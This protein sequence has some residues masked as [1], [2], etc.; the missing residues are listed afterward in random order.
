MSDSELEQTV[1]QLQ[2]QLRAREAELQQAMNR[3]H[4]LE[5]C[6]D[7][8]VLFG[9]DLSPTFLN[10][11]GARLYQHIHAGSIDAAETYTADQVHSLEEVLLISVFESGQPATVGYKA[12]HPAQ[13]PSIEARYFPEEI[14]DGKV[15]S[16]LAILRDDT[17]R[18]RASESMQVNETL[19][20]AAVAHA[21]VKIYAQD[22]EL[23]YQW[24]YDQ[25]SG[26]MDQ[27][28]PGK[29]DQDFYSPADAEKLNQIKR[30]VLESGKSLREMVDL[31]LRN[32]VRS[33]ELYI[34]PMRN[35]GEITGL[36]CTSLDI[37]E[38]KRTAQQLAQLA[39]ENQAQKDRLAQQNAFLQGIF[40]ASPAGIAVLVGEELEHG[41][42]NP[43]YRSMLPHP[44][45]D[46]LGRP[47]IEVWPQAENFRGSWIAQRVLQ[48]GNP[49]HLD[50]YPQQFADGATRY[51]GIN[52][53]RL[54]WE[55]R[56][57]VL[58]VL[59]DVTSLEAATQL[60]EA[61]ADEARKRAAEAQESWS[62]L[63]ASEQKLRL[64]LAAAHMGSWVYDPQTGMVEYDEPAQKLYDVPAGW[65]LHS[66]VY[67]NRYH[68]EDI[69]TMQKAEQKATD[70]HGDGRYLVDYRVR[71]PDGTWRWLRVWGQVQFT[72]EGANRRA[73]WMIGASRDITER[74]QMEVMLR[75]NEE[76]FRS[77]FANAAIGFAM[78]DP[79]GK[80]ADANAAYCQLTGYTIEEL[81]KLKSSDLFYPDDYTENMRLTDEMLAG[82]ISDYVVENRYVRKNKQAVWV[83][84][85]VSMVRDDHSAPKWIILL[86]ENISQR[87]QAEEAVHRY[88]AQLEQLNRELA[89]TNRELKDFAYI[90]SHDLQEPLRKVSKF[91]EMLK[92]NY[93]AVLAEGGSEYVDRMINASQR[94]Q[95]MISGLL[96]YS[97]ISTRGSSFTEVNL[98]ETAR[99]VLSDLEIRLEQTGGAVELG[100]LPV[101]EADPL[102][103]RQLFQN[104]IGNALKFHQDGIPPQVKV[105][106]EECAQRD[107]KSGC[108]Q[109]VVQD[110]G[111]GFESHLADKLF[112]P[113]VRLH[114]RSAYEGTGMGLAICRKI[115]ERH[116]G[117]IAVSSQPEQG[118]AF[119]ITLPMRQSK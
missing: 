108:I 93:G 104:L 65:L 36:L 43:A 105:W 87:K 17:G 45:D 73:G 70:P 52:I 26:L 82:Q 74:K 28:Y 30:Q 88:T 111:I 7:G 102:Q 76:K 107:Q 58:M 54:D 57:A 48:S 118:T 18:K 61:A 56:P 1:R 84:K 119:T 62:K 75:E 90:A 72:G 110:N 47:Y 97:R 94:M 64:A 13:R 14:V 89:F 91:G 21:G 113:F 20:R 53:S 19:V 50:R 103:I 51:Y 114:G 4:W 27:A 8:Y 115:V 77:A 79:T 95:E 83:R 85:S 98:E 37:T 101:I 55:G 2:A 112:Q 92:E 81:Q 35:E 46:P 10:P 69:P 86:V 38:R 59:W 12:W 34:E 5:A 68:P 15:R 106:A 67:H 29:T 41:F 109:L 66:W 33:F 63:E 3:Q 44:T 31:T 96:D 11:A 23:C 16:V 71:R 9:P 22:R 40:D 24:V 60:A 117:T 78:T 6:P 80:F 25:Q 42:V 32:E 39:R 49:V 99:E 116:G 100:S